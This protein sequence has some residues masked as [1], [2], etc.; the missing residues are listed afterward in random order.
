MARIFKSFTG[1]GAMPGAA[2]AFAEIGTA[3]GAVATATPLS[4]LASLYPTDIPIG[5]ATGRAERVSIATAD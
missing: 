5:A 3:I 2:E 1:A 4:P